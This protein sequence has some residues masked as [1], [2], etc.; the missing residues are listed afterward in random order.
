MKIKALFSS[1]FLITIGMYSFYFGSGLAD[2]YIHIASILMSLVLFF[3]G[4]FCLYHLADC[5]I[6]KKRKTLAVYI[7]QRTCKKNCAH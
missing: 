4:I 6:A 5:Y 2:G 3:M 7:R 1:I